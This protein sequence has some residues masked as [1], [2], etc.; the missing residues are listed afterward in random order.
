MGDQVAEQVTP[1]VEQNSEPAEHESVIPSGMLAKAVECL[2]GV[3]GW[4]GVRASQLRQTVVEGGLTNGL[5]KLTHSDDSSLQVLVRVYGGGTDRLFDRKT[6]IAA[7]QAL[8]GVGASP[9]CYGTFQ[10]GRLEE[11][12][13]G[14]TLGRE[15]IKEHHRIEQIATTVAKFHTSNP[16]I[17]GPR[18][19]VLMGVIATWLADAKRRLASSLSERD[20][21][22]IASSSFDFTLDNLDKE[23]EE[24]KA[25]LATAKS[26]VAF[27][28]HDLIA[29]NF[30]DVGGEVRL[31]D[32][33][34]GW[35]DNVAMDIGN[36]W[37]EWTVNYDYELYPHYEIKHSN[38]PT[39]AQQRRFVTAYLTAAS[40]EGAAPTEHE[41]TEL[42]TEANMFTMAAHFMWA[43][44]GFMQAGSST[45]EF[46]HMQYGKDRMEMYAECK[47]R[48]LATGRV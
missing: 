21:A 20:R 35:Y 28:H 5:Y 4:S 34:Y 37:L 48:F 33:E 31:I 9:R 45:I 46:G 23:Y 3:D 38:F 30:I 17:N 40:A 7:F 36:H 1:L 14:A 42:L 22:V 41:I 25:I 10:G 24:M 16:P 15:Q 39:E 44:W 2:R 11:F 27:V 12:L 8:S 13:L 29:G 26:P 47:R 32:F 18:E 43:C 19:N 6:E